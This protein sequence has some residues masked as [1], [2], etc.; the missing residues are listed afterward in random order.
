MHCVLTFQISHWNNN[1]S[2]SKCSRPEY[3]ARYEL[4]GNGRSYQCY[5]EFSQTMASTPSVIL[6]LTFWATIKISIGQR[7]VQIPFCCDG[8]SFL[9]IKDYQCTK[10]KTADERMFIF[11][12]K[13]EPLIEKL[14]ENLKRL[15]FAQIN[16]HGNGE[17]ETFNVFRKCINKFVITIVIVLHI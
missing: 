1:Y 9:D 5:L 7:A 6:S 15:T 4:A 14:D 10:F 11:P 16:F 12:P 2:L 17:I 8:D 13:S 3:H